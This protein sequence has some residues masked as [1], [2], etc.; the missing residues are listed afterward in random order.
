MYVLGC[1]RSEANT[2][3]AFANTLDIDVIGPLAALKVTYLQC[4][5]GFDDSKS[6]TSRWGGA[7]F[8]DFSRNSEQKLGG[9]I[10][11]LVRGQWELECIE[12]EEAGV[13]I[14]LLYLR[15]GRALYE[16]LV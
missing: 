5:K 2:R 9:R 4:C 8:S 6:G 15:A 13:P 14:L 7:L 11:V 10:S 1:N 12:S 16:H 3:Q